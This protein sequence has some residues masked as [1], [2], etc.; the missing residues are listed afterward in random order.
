MNF[1]LKY[2]ETFLLVAE[3]L[4]FTEAAKRLNTSKTA[5]SNQIRKLET[6]LEV[7]LLIRTTRQVQL[8]H[9]GHLLYKQCDSLRAAIFETRHLL[10]SF[11]TKPSGVLNISCNPYL[12]DNHILKSIQVY[13]LRFPEMKVVVKSND[14]MLDLKKSSID[15][16]I[17]VSWEAPDDVVRKRFTDTRYCLCASPQYLDK[18]SIPKTIDALKELDFIHLGGRGLTPKLIS[19]KKEETI[20]M[21]SS[22]VMHSAVFLKQAVLSGLGIAQLHDYMVKE[23]LANGALIEL[24]PQLFLPKIPLYLYFMRQRYIEPKVRQFIQCLERDAK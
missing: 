10:K 3:C 4:S 24:M 9:E 16:M 2:F 6:E 13:Q 19:L 1:D 18:H 17:G 15:L 5:I 8:T 20:P 7:D 12:M 22:L 14:K 11:H 21:P 23:E